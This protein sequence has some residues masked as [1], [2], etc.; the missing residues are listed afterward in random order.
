MWPAYAL[1][2][3][4]L[5]L[6]VAAVLFLMG[7]LI[8]INPIWQWGP[9]HT[10]LSENGAQP[11]WYIGWLIG[12]LRLM[13]N[14][15][16]VIHGRTIIPEPFWGG[17]G[18]PLFV[19]AVLYAWPAIE[20]RTTRDRRRHDLLD[21]PRDHPTRTAIGAAFLSWVVIIFAVGATDRVYYR[22]HISYVGEI[23]FWRIGVWVLPIVVFVITRAVARALRRSEARPLRGWQGA[24]IRRDSKNGA[25]VLEESVGDEPGHITE[26][27]VGTSPGSDS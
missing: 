25:R 17:A 2:S 18:F 27:P 26:P 11:D 13:P 12:A 23:H 4:G 3:I 15:E 10:Y 14:W 16:L 9:Y 8:Q 5:M 7:G 6:A 21:R 1:R 20:R 22:L 19:F 24:V